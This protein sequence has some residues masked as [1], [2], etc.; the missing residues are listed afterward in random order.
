MKYY[1]ALLNEFSLDASFIS[2]AEKKAVL[3]ALIIPSLL[4]MATANILVS[5]TWIGLIALLYITKL[6]DK[7]ENSKAFFT[8]IG[9][10]SAIFMI[11]LISII[12][13]SL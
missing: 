9:Y 5:L 13:L 7:K 6:S 2:E 11:G 3:N 12:T 4:L 10:E 1:N 8:L